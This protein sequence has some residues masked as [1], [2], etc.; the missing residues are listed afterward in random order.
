MSYVKFGTSGADTTSPYQGDQFAPDVNDFIFS[1]GG[2]DVID[3]K[4][5]NDYLEGGDGADK[6]W[7]GAGED[8]LVAATIS[9][10][11]SAAVDTLN[12]GAGNDTYFV[13]SGDLVDETSDGY[14]D[15][16]NSGTDSTTDAG[17][18]D[19]VNTDATYTLQTNVENITV[20]GSS[21]VTATGNA[22]TNRLIGNGSTSL[23]GLAGNDT[24]YVSGSDTVTESSA[25]GGTDIVYSSV[26]FTLGSNVENL[27]L[28]GSGGL[29]GTGNS[30][31]NTLRGDNSGTGS[32]TLVGAAGNDTYYVGTGDSI[33]DSGGTADIAYTAVDFDMS[34]AATTV[35]N[36]TITG[37]TTG[38][39][40]T[41]NSLANI[42][43]AET[44]T[45]ANV[46]S[47]GAGNDTYYVST[48]DT[49]SE[50]SS[51]GTDLVSSSVNFTLTDVDVENLTLTGT[52]GTGTGNASD[53]IIT[54]NSSNNTL[55][56]DTGNDSLDGGSGNDTITGGSAGNDQINGGL[57]FD[58]LTGG[59]GTDTFVFNSA[60]TNNVD[61]IADYDTSGADAIKL[62][63]GVMTGL[64][65]TTGALTAAAY[66]EGTGTGTVPTVT[67]TAQHILYNTTDGALYY[68]S[69]GSGSNLA[70]KFAQLTGVP[71]L[72][73][74]DFTII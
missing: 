15:G 42:I 46:L 40:V 54:G 71:A 63:N 47:G 10:D 53:N 48:G 70:V 68:D 72:T 27:T 60:L 29:T 12:G 16:D 19:T 9:A 2:A 58:S 62:E 8:T 32:D 11:D 20:V 18:T 5:G 1:L 6:L 57:G 14:G 52:A 35:E 13:H 59:G 51:E 30:L 28:T 37:S 21:A 34:S 24:Y 45:A 66:V 64:G 43:H 26:A 38:I 23:N 25:S 4:T 49:V 61:T 55:D 74:A 7:G 17:G 41:G 36:L 31:A 33:T 56:G 50:A 39:D 44:N 73:N 3:G 67:T 22:S 69:D 65:T